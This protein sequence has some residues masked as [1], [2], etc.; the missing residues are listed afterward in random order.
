[1]LISFLLR[2]VK[3]PTCYGGDGTASPAALVSLVT[4]AAFYFPVVAVLFKNVVMELSGMRYFR[5][6]LNA[7]SFPSSIQVITVRSLTL[8]FSATSWTV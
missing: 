3:V 4:G 8:N 5:P 2:I 6:I 1:M 7:A